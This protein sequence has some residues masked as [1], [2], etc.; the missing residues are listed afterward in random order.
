MSTSKRTVSDTSGLAS[1]NLYCAQCQA[2][3]GIFDNEWIRLTSSYA[4]SREKGTHFGTEVGQ[5]TQIVP[6][7]PS[8][9]SAEGC[10]MAEVFCR[11]CSNMVGQYCKKAPDASKQPLVDQYFYK[12]SRTFLKNSY[13]NVKVEPLFAYT[14]DESGSTPGSRPSPGPRTS[15]TPTSRWLNTPLREASRTPSVQTVTR[16]ALRNQSIVPSLQYEKPFHPPSDGI[17]ENFEASQHAMDV[18]KQEL[19]AQ[20]SMLR[21]HSARL[22]KQGGQVSSHETSFRDHDARIEDQGNCIRAQASRILEQEDLIS[23]QRRTIES[24]ENQLTVLSS[25]VARLQRSMDDLGTPVQDTGSDHHRE[26]SSRKGQVDFVGS[27]ESLV[28]AMKEAQSSTHEVRILR[29]QNQGLQTRLASV[30][31]NIGTVANNDADGDESPGPTGTESM[32][33]LGK[34]KRDAPNSK[35]SSSQPVESPG[36]REKR[37]VR[38]N[39]QSST[40]M[41]TPQ[42][43]H[44]HV[45]PVQDLS[46]TSFDQPPQP[47]EDDA[48][49]TDVQRGTRVAQAHNSHNLFNRD[50]KPQA[51][52]HGTDTLQDRVMED[53][54]ATN[55]MR[56]ADTSMGLDGS[57]AAT[58]N[59]PLPAQTAY[60][61]TTPAKSDARVESTIIDV[62]TMPPDSPELPTRMTTRASA[63]A[64]RSDSNSKDRDPANLIP[65]VPQTVSR[66]ELPE[67]S[68]SLPSSDNVQ[69]RSRLPSVQAAGKVLGI[70]L[71]PLQGLHQAF[72]VKPNS[73]QRVTSTP[74]SQ[75]AVTDIVLASSGTM[76]H[77]SGLQDEPSRSVRAPE[78]EAP[79][80]TVVL[81]AAAP[82][83]ATAPDTVFVEDNSMFDDNVDFSDEDDIDFASAESQAAPTI[84]DPNRR[85][86]DTWI[87]RDMRSMAPEPSKRR[88]TVSNPG[89]KYLTLDRVRIA[90]PQTW[91]DALSKGLEPKLVRPPP[92]NR[93][94]LDLHE[95]L[96]ML[97]LAEWIPRSK[98]SKEYRDLVA[99]ARSKYRNARLAEVLQEKGLSHEHASS[100]VQPEEVREVSVVTSSKTVLSPLENPRATSALQNGITP[101]DENSQ[102]SQA[103][104]DKG[105]DQVEDRQEDQRE[106]RL[107][108]A[109]ARRSSASLDA[110]IN[111]SEQIL[112]GTLTSSG[113]LNED[114]RST[115]THTTEGT[116]GLQPTMT[117][118]YDEVQPALQARR[119]IMTMNHDSAEVTARYEAQQPLS[120]Q[121]KGRGRPRRSQGPAI[122]AVSNR[123]NGKEHTPVSGT[124][125][126]AQAGGAAQPRRLLPAPIPFPAER[127]KLLESMRSRAQ[128]KE[129][130]IA[131]RDL[132]A[133]QAMEAMER[134]EFGA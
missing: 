37:L 36:T 132:M 55:E 10:E 109:Q 2:Q 51:N 102:M 126:A 14:P 28:Q 112:Q 43:L 50:S 44:N 57:P 96:K 21:E 63:K 127:Q 123:G 108:R 87:D 47:D 53:Q 97:G 113:M 58:L 4:R 62:D 92:I 107:T 80:Q 101:G 83:T 120:M 67:V 78:P 98:K 90:T 24:H 23:E 114:T 128:Q 5:R 99:A 94:E 133:K 29:E 42:S 95:E 69:D 68:Q 1:V 30:L 25:Q 85:V 105:N 40:Q 64:N 32:Q 59:Q 35:L 3:I 122:A 61:R 116:S 54:L 46:A 18:L 33:V 26:I 110:I 134:D 48:I 89:P 65:T 49:E 75:T 79:S 19:A 45:S 103:I 100:S 86:T 130:A 31:G 20:N 76:E 39:E 41:P 72:V 38:F 111:A 11:K 73:H 56:V 34:R 17:D 9:R 117:S 124:P 8:P 119:D 15:M 91:S 121:K 12:L 74:L 6:G 81:A 84:L 131:A 82:Q 118:V 60:H 70:N 71:E 125:S 106:P 66:P 27:F 13:T 88:K 129:E 52:S 115:G 77:G 104:Q 7:G 16:S 22:S 93:R